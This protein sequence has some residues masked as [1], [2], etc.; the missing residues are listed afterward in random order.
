MLAGPDAGAVEASVDGDEFQSV[1]LYH[2]FSAGLHYPRTIMF[3]T[4]LSDGKHTLRL[5]ISD[6]KNAKSKGHAVR[7]LQFAGN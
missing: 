6:T 1:D 7:I 3:A 4:D 2:R 5:R